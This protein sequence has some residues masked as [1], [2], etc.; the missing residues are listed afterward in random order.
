M[1]T[2]CTIAADYLANGKLVAIPTETVYG[3]AANALLPLAVADI[4]VVKNRPQFNPIIIHCASWKLAQKYTSNVPAVIHV[5]AK[6]FAP[7]PI[8]FL[9]NKAAIIP[10]IVTAGS[11]KVAI[12]IPNH[13]LLLQL[14]LQINFPLAAPSANPSGYV[15]PTSAVHVLA[16]LQGKI[17]YILDGGKCTVGLESTIVGTDENDSLVLYRHGGISK[18]QLEQTVG[19]TIKDET[20]TTNNT[21]VTPGQ[22]LVHYATN[23]PLVVGNI[24][25]LLPLYTNKKV[26]V[27]SFSTTH[28]HKAIVHQITL[29][30]SGVLHEAAA[31]LFAAMREMDTKNIDIIL[32][33]YF[34]NEGI[35]M[36]INDRLFKAS[37]NKPILSNLYPKYF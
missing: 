10:D 7:G 6:K 34:P 23:I 20:I 32:A 24:H 1:G 13:P 4:F 17:P 12:R 16:N 14:L 2:D 37:N 27:L 25:A 18:A 22:L 33:E 11:N 29:S 19:Y 36:A 5:L 21:P 8:T 3:L 31:N 28:Q 9:V 35:G 30:A 15:S 26:G